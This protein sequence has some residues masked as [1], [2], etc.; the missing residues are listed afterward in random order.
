[1][2]KHMKLQVLRER[3]GRRAG[4]G[5]AKFLNV[6]KMWDFCLFIEQDKR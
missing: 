5:G 4:E 3:G 2:K 1:M 6:N